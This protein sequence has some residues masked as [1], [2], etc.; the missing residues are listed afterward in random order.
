MLFKL[1][2]YLLI[3]PN[4]KQIISSDAYLYIWWMECSKGPLWG[5]KGGEVAAEGWPLT[6]CRP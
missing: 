3:Q 5:P 2:L 6:M 1:L 4:T